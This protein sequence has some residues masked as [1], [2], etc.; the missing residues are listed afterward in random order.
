M[1]H[2][3]L[4]TFYTELQD[5]CCRVDFVILSSIIDV[6]DLSLD[7]LFRSLAGDEL[8]SDSL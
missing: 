3:V 8:C 4:A 7:H 2:T 5:A 6:A 1:E